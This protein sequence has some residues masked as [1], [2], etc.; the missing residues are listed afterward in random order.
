MNPAAKT[1]NVHALEWIQIHI[2]EF[3]SGALPFPEASP[4]RLAICTIATKKK[5]IIALSPHADDVEIAM[6]GTIAKYIN[7]GHNVTIIT[8]ILPKENIDGNIDDLMSKNRRK[9]Q[10]KA[11]KILGANLE[12]LNYGGEILIKTDLNLVSDISTSETLSP[13]ILYDPL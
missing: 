6:G 13:I 4:H 11:A 5:N 12:I 7:E 8:A 9:E 10:E 3:S 1:K 2:H